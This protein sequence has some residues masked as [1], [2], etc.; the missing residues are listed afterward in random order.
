M[1]EA[2]KQRLESQL[3][4]IANEL[5]GKMDADQ[6]RDYILGFIFYKY[7]SEKQ[8]IFANKLLETEEVKDYRL[9]TD[10]DDLEAIREESLEKLGYFLKPQELF[11]A[12]AARGNV[13][14]DEDDEETAGNFILEDLQSILNAIEQSTMGSESEDDC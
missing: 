1:T 3:W 12:I 2:Q 6:F 14:V 5:R 7:L 13:K 4:K 9:V 11:S 10:A 8:Y